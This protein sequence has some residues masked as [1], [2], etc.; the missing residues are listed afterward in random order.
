MPSK[1]P[2]IANKPHVIEATLKARRTVAEGVVEVVIAHADG[3][4]S[5]NAGQSCRIT[6]PK[7]IFPDDNGGS[8]EFSIISSP[9]STDSITIAFH[10]SDSGFK[11]TLLAMPIGGQLQ[12]NG[13]F[14]LDSFALPED[15]TRPIVCVAGDVG[16]APFLS[17]LSVAT[18]TGFTGPITVLYANKEI[19]QAAYIDQLRVMAGAHPNLKIVERYGPVDTSF[20][21]TQLQK[22]EDTSLWY[23][24]GS[25]S[26]V[27][28]VRISLQG[29][30]IDARDIRNEEMPG[31]GVTVHLPTP[32]ESRVPKKLIPSDESTVL[33]SALD[34]TAI[35]SMT[36]AQG[37]IT[38]A[39]KLFQ[40]MSGYSAE[41]LKG[42][43]SR[44]LKSGEHTPEFYKDMWSTI[45]AGQ[46]WRNEIKNQARDGSYYWTDMSIAPIVGVNGRTE[47]YVAVCFPVTEKRRIQ[48][49]L[50]QSQNRQALILDNLAEIVYMIAIDPR[51]GKQTVDFV[52]K[53]VMTIMGYDQNEVVEDPMLWSSRMH[54]DDMARATEFRAHLVSD[55]KP[56]SCLYRL[57]HKNGEYKLLEDSVVPHVAKNGSLMLFGVA[58]DMTEIS[59]KQAAT[60]EALHRLAEL[61]ENAPVGIF[62]NSVGP[63]GH[64]IEVNWAFVSMFDMASKVEMLGYD[65]R[66]LFQEPTTGTAFMNR[67]LKNGE[68]KDELLPLKTMKGRPIWGLVTAVKKQANDGTVF[69]DGFIVDATERKY[70]EQ[71]SIAT[72]LADFSASHVD[73][74][75]IFDYVVKAVARALNVRFSKIL[76]LSPTGDSLLLRAGVGWKDGYVGSASVSAG[77]ES[78]AGYTLSS[79]DA[80]IVT[81]LATETR[82]SGPQLLNDHG[83]ISGISVVIRGV[84][85]QPYGVLGAH[86]DVRRPF[87]REDADFMK[88]TANIV[89]VAIE[90]QDAIKKNLELLTLKNK[91]IQIVSHQFRTPLNAIRWNLESLLADDLGVLQPAQKEFLR[92]TYNAN[93]E[94][95]ERIHDLLL[96][97]DIE[98][99]RVMLIKEEFSFDGLWNSVLVG[100]KRKCQIKS[101]SCEYEPSPVLIPSVVGDPEKIRVVFEKL[102]ENATSYTATGGKAKAR[103]SLLAN[104][105]RFEVTDNGVG[106]PYVE[107]ERI[108]ARF[109]R[110]SNASTMRPDASG[111]GLG[112]AKYLVELHGG[113]I[114]FSSQEGVGSTFWFELPLKVALVGGGKMTRRPKIA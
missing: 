92:V 18:E 78:Q 73:I 98:E 44:I 84:S 58:R 81:D 113:T 17:M 8:R 32:A 11:R 108:F 48:S 54:P 95:I 23:I 6:L 112:I 15:K 91:F 107:Q 24:A 30:G 96:A 40:D 68:V 70:A 106:I 2:T 52:S 80:V 1:K 5:F 103:I 82:F 90:R 62:R 64:F 13:P 79:N 49:D 100:W 89:G 25:S 26:L 86:S 61:T 36:D 88:M 42:Q 75:A 94:V 50:L 45:T 37:S 67:I 114:G 57:R 99:N 77:G 83:I 14:G 28:S 46:V 66:D 4:F 102:V 12:V 21:K 56:N 71:R 104:T 87:T 101:I 74:K 34:R 39:N 59:E 16:I 51:S 65:M 31:L 55:M 38:Y 72:D 10:P 7:L 47:G 85:G 93:I 97:L 69:F 60:D 109:Y 53:A 27:A 110:A 43:N 29:L 111:L 33:L 76:E 3:V 22:N 20:L 35:V 9:T 41:E 63:A 19:S 105:I